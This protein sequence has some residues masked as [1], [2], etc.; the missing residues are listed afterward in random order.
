MSYFRVDPIAVSESAGFADFVIRLDAALAVEARVNYGIDAGTAAGNQD[1]RGQSGTLIFAPGETS[2]TVRVELLDGNVVEPTEI[3]WIDLNTAVNA[4][5]PQRWT[6]AMIYDNDAA[7]GTPGLVV[8]NVAVDE[9]ARTANFFVYLTQPST[10]PVSVSYATADGTA[11]AGQDYQA[12]AGLLNFGAGEM[13]KTVSVP[14]INDNLAENDEFFHLVLANPSGATLSAG[15]GSAMIGRNDAPPVGQ[16]QVLSRAVAASEGETLAQFLVYLSAPSTNEVRVNFGIDAGT[17]AGNADFRGYSGTLV[18]APGET[19]KALPVPVI[20][21]TA[22]EPT[23]VFWLD[24]NTAVNA[25]VPQRWTPALIVDNDGATGTPAITA[26]EVVVDETA[27]RALVVVSLDRP[28]VSPVTVAWATADS[29]AQA[30]EDYRAGSGVLRFEPGETVKTISVDVFDDVLAERDEF[31]HVVLANP[32]GATLADAVGSVMIARNDTPPVGQPYVGAVPL[33]A[34]EGDTVAD[35]VVYL[36]APSPNEVRVNFGIDAG[37]AAGNADFRGYAGTLVFAPGETVKTLPVPVID[38]TSAEPTEVF[39]L[40]LNTP[41]N[42][43]VSQ[44]W[45]PALI[46][47]N[48]GATGTPLVSIGDAV[49]DESA[50]LAHLL[51]SLSRPSV[52]T[53]TVPWATAD[54]T[55]EAGSDYAAAS[56]VLSFAPGETAKTV[57]LNLV[58]DDLAEGDEFFQVVLGNPGNATLADAVGAVMIS[59]SDTPPVGQPQILATPLV[60]AEGDTFASFVVQLSAASSNEVRVNFNVGAG[61]AAGNADFRGYAGTLVF[62]PGETAKALPVPV[63]DDTVAE[64]T[65]IFNL[66]LNSAVNAT[67]PQRYTS[68]TLVDNDSGF[69]VYSYGISNDQYTVTS[70]LDRVVEGLRGG[71]DTVHAAI[72]YTLPEDVENLVLTGAALN[73]IGNAAH[74]VFRGSA[75]N[76]IL[77]GQGGIDTVVYGAT[78]ADTTLGRTAVGYT[79]TTSADGADSLL[80]IERLKFADISVALDVGAGQSAGQTVLLLGAALPGQLVYDSSKQELLGSVI[81]LFDAGYSLRELSGALL[82]LPVWDVLTGQAV[83]TNLD[84]ANYLLTNVNGRMPDQTELDA[85]VNALNTESFQGDW[86]AGL[87]SSPANQFHLDLVGLADTGLD[88]S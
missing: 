42:A 22:A 77:D 24:L 36:S 32:A 3:F 26:G 39:W 6:P 88:F 71:I 10:L 70:L 73:G 65:E 44:R 11:A 34:G 83:P 86:L 1:F 5:V 62:A 25:V 87:A 74:N 78:R 67:V 81:E 84:I 53:V 64:G 50:Q 27:Q 59:R 13:V 61:T 15:T 16:P 20:D 43:V 52:S 35:F 76:N 79:L 51:V 17:A 28:S 56:G 9:T 7:A 72:S 18:F 4:V 69:T 54:D 55:A 46:V 40:D 19:L 21:D 38:D 41:V 85:A 58:D 33:A 8:G 75:A 23:E 14:L 57:T 37:T 12:T 31:F 63:I 82:R 60:V 80:N 45:T 68:A 48:D 66:D 47:D 49:V 29:T 30:G 2:K